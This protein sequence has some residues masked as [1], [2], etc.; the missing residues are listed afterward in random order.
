MKTPTEPQRRALEVLADLEA[1][2]SGYLSN[3]TDYARGY[4]AERVAEPLAR[5]GLIDLT[6]HG[7]RPGGRATITDAGR[8][9]LEATK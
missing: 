1:G 5:A 9:W 8:A 3:V 4:I 6:Y 7:T 2:R